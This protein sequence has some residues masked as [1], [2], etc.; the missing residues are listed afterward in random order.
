M[1]VAV[2]KT[3]ESLAHQK[4]DFGIYISGSK[5]DRSKGCKKFGRENTANAPSFYSSFYGNDFFA[6]IKIIPPYRLPNW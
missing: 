3:A 4:R 5:L 6:Q 2:G 1:P